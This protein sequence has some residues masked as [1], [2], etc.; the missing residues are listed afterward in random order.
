MGIG[1]RVSLYAEGRLGEP[2]ALLG[3]HEIAA[4][5]GYASGQPAY[6]HFGLGKAEKAEV[7]VVLPRAGRRSRSLRHLADHLAITGAGTVHDSGSSEGAGW[8]SAGGATHTVT[9]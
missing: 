5:Y 6:A 3:C 9:A 2:A 7:E 1:A 8:P 4:G